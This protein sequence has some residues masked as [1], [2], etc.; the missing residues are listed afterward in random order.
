MNFHFNRNEIID[1]LLRC[2]QFSRRFPIRVSA[3][4]R[5]EHAGNKCARAKREISRPEMCCK[6]LQNGINRWKV[7]TAKN[8][9]KRKVQTAKA[10][11]TDICAILNFRSEETG[12][13]QKPSQRQK[14]GHAKR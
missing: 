11:H 1:S 3:R 7:E 12:H 2:H 14:K 6:I 9:G 10:T 4:V 13:Q 8:V 5:S